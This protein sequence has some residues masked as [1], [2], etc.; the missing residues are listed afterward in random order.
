GIRDFH[1]TGV[2]TCALPIFKRVLTNVKT[3]GTWGEV[4]LA[5]LLEQL[6]VPE[7]YGCNVAPVP[8]SNERVEFAIRLPGSGDGTPVW[9]PI[10]EVGRASCR[11]GGYF[12]DGS[13]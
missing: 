13:G 5:S 8:G 6:L 11:E 12:A 2:Q 10:D 7:Q 9:L 1:V 3:R 4:Q